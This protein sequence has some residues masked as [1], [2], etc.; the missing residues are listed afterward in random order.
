MVPNPVVGAKIGKCKTEAKIP[1]CEYF[2][3]AKHLG[4]LDDGGK[5]AR[6]NYARWAKD[7]FP[8]SLTDLSTKH[9]NDCLDKHETSVDLADPACVGAEALNTCTWALQ[10]Q[11]KC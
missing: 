11:L 1:A 3:V 6:A 4:L 7:T 2:C 8:G 10:P 9:F 5:P